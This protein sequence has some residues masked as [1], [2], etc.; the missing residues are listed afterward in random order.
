MSAA[1]IQEI[2]ARSLL[3]HRIGTLKIPEC[4]LYD[5]QQKTFFRL[6]RRSQTLNV[7]FLNQGSHT[8]E[9]PLLVELSLSTAP[10]SAPGRGEAQTRDSGLLPRVQSRAQ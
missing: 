3:T 7:E 1:I 8:V 6:Q 10:G 2:G 4:R 9:I 5:R